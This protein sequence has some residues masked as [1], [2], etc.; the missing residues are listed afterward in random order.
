MIQIK[1]LKRP[2]KRSGNALK[3]GEVSEIKSWGISI[4]NN[5]KETLYVDRVGKKK[6]K[7]KKQVLRSL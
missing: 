3:P 6:S 4:I 7:T 1:K 5:S 2:N